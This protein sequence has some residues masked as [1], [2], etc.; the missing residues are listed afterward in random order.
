MELLS[1]LCTCQ[2]TFF[3]VIVHLATFF[4]THSFCSFGFISEF[5]L[6]VFVVFISVRSGHL[7]SSILVVVLLGPFSLF[8]LS[9][10]LGSSVSVGLIS[11]G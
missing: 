4:S 5:A 10:I 2:L 11:W 9:G 8:V 6:S 3:L 1:S 7:L